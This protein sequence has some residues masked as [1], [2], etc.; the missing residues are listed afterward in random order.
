MDMDAD[1]LA[2]MPFVALA[3]TAVLAL[4]LGVGAALSVIARHGP[5]ERFRCP[6]LR[7]DVEVTFDS[8]GGHRRAVLR[9]SAFGPAEEIDCRTPCVASEDIAP[10]A[11]R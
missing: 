4:L 9:C 11:A 6:F 10:H 7:R 1:F 3:G 2:A 5:P 8:W